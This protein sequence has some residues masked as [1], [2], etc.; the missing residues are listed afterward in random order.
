MECKLD[1]DITDEDPLIL[2]WIATARELA[3]ESTG[4]VFIDSHWELSLSEFPCNGHIRLPKGPLI[5][6][7]GISY[8]DR[9]EVFQLLD[10]AN[11]VEVFDNPPAIVWNSN[12]PCWPVTR[13]T[14][15][16]VRIELRMGYD[17]G[18]SPGD[19]SRVPRLAKKAIRMMVAHWYEN[20][21][22]VATETRNTPTEMPYGF[23]DLLQP[24]R[25]IF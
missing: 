14:P 23:A 16:A 20:R 21:E 17:S 2:E 12:A 13:C 19:A 4:Q 25:I 1:A 10:P 15:G 5:G 7:V 8:R 22:A 3:E 18:G 9:E 6:V 11:Y 24:L